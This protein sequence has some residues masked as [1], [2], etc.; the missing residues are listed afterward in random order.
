M[1]VA[2][3]A[4]VGAR[5]GQSRPQVGAARRP[6]LLRLPAVFIA[7]LAATSLIP[8]VAS[9]P[10]LRWSILGAAGVLLVGNL[11]LYA[12]ARTRQRS[13]T[14]EFVARRPHYM[15]ACLQSIIYVYWGY[16]WRP[17]YD[18]VPLIAAQLA[19]AYAFDMLLAWSHRD[20][21]TLGFGQF[22]IIFS[23]NLFI[24]FKPEWYYLQFALIALGFA[25]KEFIRWQKDGHSAHIFNP[26]SFP[27][28]IFSVVL[29]ATASTSM[30]Y[31]VEIATTQFNP[32][33]IYLLL[34]LIGLPGQYFFGVTPM[35]MTAVVTTYLFGLVYFA[36]TGTYF[37]IDSYI[38]V[39]VF[40]GMHLLF[41]DPAT[42]PRT[43]LGRIAYG[44]L[45]ALGNI[46]L[47]E[48]LGRFGIPTFY[49]KL[50]PV[51]LM[52]LSIRA[53]DRLAES[54]S[55]RAINPANL[56]RA[57]APRQRHLAYMTV[58]M[59]AFAG[60]SSV[61]AVGDA[62]PGHRVPF[63]QQ[64]C[65][66]NLRNGCSTLANI[67]AKYCAD[68]SG[69]ACNEVGVL[70]AQRKVDRPERAEE[71]FQ[72]ACA[73][74]FLSGCQNVALVRTSG[75]A[76]VRRAQPG[77]RD[78]P[79]ILRIGKG[80]LPDTTPL[81]L[82][83]RAC[84]QGFMNGCQELAGT[85]LKGQGTP[86]DPSKA[87]TALERAC[88]GGFG[89]GCSDLGLMHFSGDGIPQDKPRGLAY[90]KQACDTGYAQACQWYAE[91]TK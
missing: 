28:A 58:W 71:N 73:Q 6:G 8:S 50:L 3:A 7:S 16:H 47:Y 10:S 64:A 54:P 36:V 27:L 78:Y 31:G 53:I 57:L 26:S 9:T 23:I 67:T 24:W 69:W 80:D 70:R 39:S 72:A 29:I 82:Y 62:H 35:T 11:L 68:G 25:A 37:F 1:A 75:A 14:L 22:P 61:Q 43:E 34:F 74:G 63:W 4:R 30:T 66:Q 81:A 76:A 15:Q 85:Y 84:E 77:L 55:L 83:G 17:V 21:Y 45:Y 46:V 44:V 91:Q 33:N 48:W 5:K 49:D 38:P 13:L 90:L 87:K 51:P 52:N 19:F 89:P 86:R 60:M 42:A 32:P 65:D 56:G 2:S 12:S 20:R 59:L 18:Q 88:S 79:I 41:T 40:L